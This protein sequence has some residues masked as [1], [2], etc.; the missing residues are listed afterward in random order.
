MMIEVVST[1]AETR[2][3]EMSKAEAAA[4]TAVMADNGMNIVTPSPELIAGLKD[5]GAKML[6]DL[7][8][9]ASPEALAII[10]TYQGN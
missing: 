1:T 3:W 8:S 9:S 7:E 10:K 2:G 4:K 5:I 6:A